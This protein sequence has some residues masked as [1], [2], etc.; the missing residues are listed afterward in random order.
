MQNGNIFEFILACYFALIELEKKIRSIVSRMNTM[1]T[2]KWPKRAP[3]YFLAVR[4][5][6][7]PLRIRHFL[8]FLAGYFQD[9]P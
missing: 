4:K 3:G 8:L 5:T 9:Q 7:E 2:R 6:F 1:K